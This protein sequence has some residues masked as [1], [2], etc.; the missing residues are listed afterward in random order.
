MGQGGKK[1]IEVRFDVRE[2]TLVGADDSS[3]FRG[4]LGSLG[5]VANQGPSAYMRRRICLIL[6]RTTTHDVSYASKELLS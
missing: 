6:V 4:V 1:V 5:R 2:L 3:F